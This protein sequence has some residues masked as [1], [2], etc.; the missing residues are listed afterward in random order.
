MSERRRSRSLLA[1]LVSVSLVLLTLDYRQGDQGSIASVQRVAMATFAPL[2]EGFAAVVRPVGGFFSSIAELG[3]LRDQV[4][5]LEADN[6]RLRELQVSRA[7]LARE[8]AELLAMLDM[9][10]R[11]GYQ[12]TGAR[13]IAQPP[14]SFEFSVLIDAGAD[15]GIATGM[16]VIDSRGLV[17]KV[18]EVSRSNARVQ[19][20]TSPNAGYAVRV[21]D[22]G[23]DG[24]LRGRGQ[25]PFQLTVL[26]P[27]A[28]IA[29][30]SEL[31][32]RAFSG[33][34]IPDGI[35]IGI[36]AGAQGEVLPGNRFL[37]V[38]PHVD[39]ANLNVV[40][41]ILDAPRHPVELPAEELLPLPEGERPP[42]PPSP[43]PTPVPSTAPV[44]TIP[45]EEQT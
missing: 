3:S 6:Q 13:V 11:L 24:L 39:F 2:Q 45:D 14:T 42:P 23:E 37:S 43:S 38:R 19:L 29:A 22:S 26:N 25:R 36:I 33:T 31:V 18:I 8:N 12:T 27:E 1:T 35:P 28:K 4:T 20:L 30:G 17:G 32:T 34:S 44:P 7:D 41:I 9:R 21:A 10:D 16:A 5:A 15:R 40:Q